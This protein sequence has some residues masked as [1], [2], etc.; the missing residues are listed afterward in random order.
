MLLLTLFPQGQSPAVV[1]GTPGVFRSSWCLFIIKLPVWLLVPQGTVLLEQCIVLGANLPAS[2]S[3]RP[4][5]T[6][7]GAARRVIP[8]RHQSFRLQG[9]VGA[10]TGCSSPREVHNLDLPNWDAVQRHTDVRESRLRFTG[11]LLIFSFTEK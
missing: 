7:A 6:P 2:A 1:R 5:Q 4:S 10:G 11:L 9:G 3:H 8:Q